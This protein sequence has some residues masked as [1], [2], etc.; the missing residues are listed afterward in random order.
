MLGGDAEVEVV[1]ERGGDELLEFGLVEDGGPLLVGDGEPGVGGDVGVVGAA[2]CG[3]SGDLR[4]RVFGAD[5][6]AGECEREDECGD[7]VCAMHYA[8]P[9]SSLR[10]IVSRWS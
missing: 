9:P 6:A 1:G 5:V 2:E 3:R 10:G 8:A 4:A 7:E